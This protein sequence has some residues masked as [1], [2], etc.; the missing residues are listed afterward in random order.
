MGA[1][2]NATTKRPIPITPLMCLYRAMRRMSQGERLNTALELVSSADAVAQRV[3]ESI[4]CFSVYDNTAEPF[5]PDHKM[6]EAPAV[7]V[8]GRS[9]A[10][11]LAQGPQTVCGI[12]DFSFTV[13]DYEVPPARTTVKAPLMRNQFE[14]GTP[15]T[16]AMRIDLLLRHEDGTP[17]IGEA[18]VATTDGY[19]TDS[20]LAL[21]QALAG[22]AQFAT[23]NQQR[24]LARY[25]P[26]AF[27]SRLQVD[28]AVV[29][30]Q[31]PV[32]AN[33]TYQTELDAAAR[34]LAGRLTTSPH[35]PKELRR[36]RFLG[37]RGEPTALSLEAF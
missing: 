5:C 19:D 18:K 36:I 6:L 1:E 10:A 32:V 23:P 14:D 31:P 13:V 28:V 25:Y 2:V 30:Y 8:G 37:V 21:V 17:M 3:R 12:G 7:I 33:A 26:H 34:L 15:S 20:L 16:A 4:E 35:F 22:A 29:A 9:L 27:T 11:A 24:R